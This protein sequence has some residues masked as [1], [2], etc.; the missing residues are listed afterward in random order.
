MTH[1]RV[2]AKLAAGFAGAVVGYFLGAFL[3]TAAGGLIANASGNGAS[4][5]AG[6]MIGAVVGLL[7][8]ALL[9][10]F[11]VGRPVVAG[12]CLGTAFV[13]GAVAFVAGFFGPLLLSPDSPQGPLLGIFITG[14]LGFVVGA[15]IGLC[16]GLTKERHRY[17][18]GSA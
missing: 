18:Q 15:V 14:P 6:N 10:G 1:T 5:E 8:G 13:V 3:G 9:G 11:L 4:G 7:G 17:G 12:W 2:G 16:L